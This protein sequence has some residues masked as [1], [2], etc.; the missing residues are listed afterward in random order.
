M[1][2]N[3]AFIDQTRKWLSDVVIAHSLC[4]FAKREFDRGSIHYDVIRDADIESLSEQV[5]MHCA[6][7]DSNPARE[8]SLLIFPD[9]LS[10][11]EDYLDVIDMANAVLNA[12]GYEGIYQVAS[13][14][15]K[16]RFAGSADDDAANY[17]NRSPY[18]MIHILREASVD[19]VLKTHPN[20]EGIPARNIKLTRELGSARLKALLAGCFD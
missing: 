7:L 20:P 17:T 5:L 4:P 10:D 12:N 3:T 11:F 18:P 2:D 6:A 8:T 15:P 13:F 1:P 16:Y 19:A 14:H 9:A